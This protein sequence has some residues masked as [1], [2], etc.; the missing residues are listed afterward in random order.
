MLLL[1]LSTL[2]LSFTATPA[3][4]QSGDIL[5]NLGPA[6]V[7]SGPDDIAVGRTLVLDASGS[8]GLGEDTNYRWFRGTS[9]VPISRSVEAVFTPEEPGSTLLRLVIETTID[10]ENI[11]LTSEKTI[12]AYDRK[13]VLI[14]DGSVASE[15]IRT[16]EQTAA[17]A[18]TYLRVI[19]AELASVPIEMEQALA[20]AIGENVQALAGAEAIVFWTDGFTGLQALAHALEGNADR[21][22]A[23]QNQNIVVLTEGSLPQLSRTLRG[24]FTVL[25]PLQILITRQE[26]LNPLLSADNMD[27][28]RSA[29]AERD[30]DFAVVDA[31][32]TVLRP[33]NFLSSL[34]NYMVTHGVPATTVILL[35][36]LPIIA[37]ILAFLKQM[38]GITTFGLFT[39]SIVA[40]SFLALGW[41]VGL[42]F[43]ISILATGYATRSAMRRWRLLYIPKVAIII[44]V[45]SLTL[46]ALLAIAAT[47]GITFA[48]DT[49]FV[50]LIMSTLAESFLTVKTEE[51]LWNAMVGISE[52]VLAALLCVFIVQWAPLQSLIIAY[53]ELLLGTILINLGLGR[54]TGLR[55]VEY[56]RFREIFRHLQEE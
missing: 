10:G 4:A 23:L 28:V 1:T 25:K 22:A 43:L 47:L 31:T 56:V 53:P 40:L 19:H 39:P 17:D 30:I 20:T 49:I 48:R 13:I 16:H 51:G 14:A 7:I 45:V 12:I 24:H 36:M 34:V 6:A 29:L 11:E 35:L 8:R 21:I 26:A 37:T 32:T 2:F 9:Q 44:T 5:P 42:F 50:L 41:P 15:K 33:W 38:I 18:G 3:W 55:L 54:W 27:E 52:T 46:L